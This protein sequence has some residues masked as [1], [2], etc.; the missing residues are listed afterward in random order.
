P[1]TEAR[2]PD[3]APSRPAN[4]TAV[5]RRQSPRAA[6]RAGREHLAKQPVSPA[7]PP[8]GEIA[9]QIALETCPWADA[10]RPRRSRDRARRTGHRRSPKSLGYGTKLL[11]WA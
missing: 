10:R 3:R 1:T 2:G 6:H 11:R 4:A 7:K 9:L 8:V 5:A